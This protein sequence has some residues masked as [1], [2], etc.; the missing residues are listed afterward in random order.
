MAGSRRSSIV[1]G[2]LARW[3]A[4][5]SLGSWQLQ[6][7][8]SLFASPAGGITAVII[9]RSNRA[10]LHV[11]AAILT[12]LR[13]AAYISSSAPGSA[14]CLICWTISSTTAPA[15][16]FVLFLAVGAV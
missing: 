1:R 3:T 16:A 9:C 6:S 4:V 15:A 10:Y 8:S 13:T 14:Q 5:A 11:S 12:I 2:G 7:S